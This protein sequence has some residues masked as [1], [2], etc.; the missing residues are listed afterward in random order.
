MLIKAGCT[1]WGL[2]WSV[3]VFGQWTT[4]ML[5]QPRWDVAIG[6]VHEKALIAGGSTTSGGSVIASNRVDIFNFAN[7]SKSTAQLSE[8][9][10]NAL[11]FTLGSKVFFC[12]GTRPGFSPSNRVDVYDD[13]TDS[14]RTAQL[15]QSRTPMAGIAWEGRI[16]VSYTHLTLPTKA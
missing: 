3:A 8:A 11:P 6:I 7:G 2:L 9:R 16:P 4:E 12:G 14:W 15:A 10:A 1:L 5:S 13:A